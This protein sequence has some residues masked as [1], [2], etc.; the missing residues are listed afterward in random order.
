MRFDIQLSEDRLHGFKRKV[1]RYDEHKCIRLFVDEKIMFIINKIAENYADIF[2]WFAFAGHDG[3]DK[4]V[5]AGFSREQ[6]TLFYMDKD[7]INGGMEINFYIWNKNIKEIEIMAVTAHDTNSENEATYNK[8]WKLRGK[9]KEEVWSE[10]SKVLT[11]YKAHGI[12]GL[13]E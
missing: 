11:A 10:I 13:I 1:G 2:I 4:D 5:K 7:D 6:M 3:N 12:K 8:S 9:S